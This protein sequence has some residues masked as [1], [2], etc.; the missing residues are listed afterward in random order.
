MPR[1]SPGTPLC[2]KSFRGFHTDVEEVLGTYLASP[3]YIDAAV[4][5]LYMS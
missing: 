4:L 2:T 3:P 5:F 1:S